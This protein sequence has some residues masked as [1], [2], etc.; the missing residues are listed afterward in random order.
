MTDTPKLGITEMEQSQSQKHVTF[1]EAMFRLDV[2]TQASV[3]DRDL[4]A[5]P[6]SPSEGDSYI[7]ASVASGDWLGAEN[8]IAAFQGGIWVIYAPQVGWRTWISDEGILA[9]WDGTAWLNLVG[10]GGNGTAAAPAYAFAADPDTGMYRNA[11]NELGFSTGGTER[12]K[13]TNTQFIISTGDLVVTNSGSN[14]LVTVNKAATADDAGFTFQNAFST[15]AQLGALGNDN[16]TIKVGGSFTTAMIINSTTAAVSLEA[17]PKFSAYLNYGQTITAGAWAK[18][19]F[20][21]ERH[22]DQTSFNTGT[23]K[24]VAPH[25]GYYMF[26]AAYVF[27]DPGS[28]IPDEMR[29]GFSINNLAPTDDRALTFGDSYNFLVSEKSSINLSACIKLSQGDT[30]EVKVFFLTNNGRILANENHFWGVQ[31]A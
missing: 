1:N 10:A 22:D 6:G 8:S 15:T 29:I 16:F 25:D 5:P 19:P 27:E 14:A 4:T 24:F 26:G 9:R 23:A 20:N 12:A 2:I 13:I 7:I 18:I 17:H 28:S 21:N 31:I 11:A 30:V 3:A